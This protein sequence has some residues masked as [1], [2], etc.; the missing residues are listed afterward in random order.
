M[1]DLPDFGA[2]P[3]VEVALGV[4]FRILPALRGLALAPLRERWR[5]VPEG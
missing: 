3:V 2:P 1:T 5:P 4:Q